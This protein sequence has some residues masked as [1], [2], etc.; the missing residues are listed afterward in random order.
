MPKVLGCVGSR[1][2]AGMSS[3]TAFCRSAISGAIIVTRAWCIHEAGSICFA[4]VSG[5]GRESSMPPE[6][7]GRLGS[8]GKVGRAQRGTLWGG[9]ILLIVVGTGVDS[10][11]MM[12]VVSLVFNKDT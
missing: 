8:R 3:G 12:R 1:G 10:K 6:M 7:T 9:S 4:A 2:F 5:V 11:L